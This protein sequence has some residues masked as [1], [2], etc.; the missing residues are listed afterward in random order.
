MFIIQGIVNSLKKLIIFQN[1]KQFMNKNNNNYQNNNNN[2]KNKNYKKMKIQLLV[3]N[4]FSKRNLHFNQNLAKN[5][6]NL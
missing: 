3:K 4:Q 1:I 6:I 5:S 2:N